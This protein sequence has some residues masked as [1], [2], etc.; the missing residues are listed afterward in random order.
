[1]KEPKS[2]SEALTSPEWVDAMRAEIDSLH[3]NGV[4]DL[5]PLPEGR[6][7]VGSKWVYKVKR[8]ADGSVERANTRSIRSTTCP[9]RS[10]TVRLRLR[11]SVGNVT[12]LSD[13]FVTIG[14]VILLDFTV[15]Y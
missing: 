6:K 2:V 11:R 9:L 12:S 4:W 8:D 5:V 15:M 14:Y 7:A 13:C 10:E 3:N 1:V